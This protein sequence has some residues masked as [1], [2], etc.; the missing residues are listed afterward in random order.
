MAYRVEITKSAD[1]QLDALSAWVIAR[2][3]HHG[4]AWFNGLEQSILSLEDH[5]ERCPIAAE[6]FDPV[7]PIRVLL[8]GRRQ[9]VYRVFFVVDEGAQIVRVIHIRHGAQQPL[10]LK[11]T[12]D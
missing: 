10:K 2:A 12:G 1:A 6:S 5:P 9:E 3:P 4:A 11:A 7:H 8:H